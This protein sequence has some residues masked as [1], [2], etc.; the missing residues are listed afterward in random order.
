MVC[1]VLRP[2]FLGDRSTTLDPV[3]RIALYLQTMNG[4][5]EGGPTTR[6]LGDENWPWLST[7]YKFWDDPPS[8]MQP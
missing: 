5:L 4:H 3:V 6:S 2:Y 7:T 8:R 1:K